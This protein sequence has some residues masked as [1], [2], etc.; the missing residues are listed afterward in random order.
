MR[1]YYEIFRIIY[2]FKKLFF[3]E[4]ENVNYTWYGLF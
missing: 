3:R 4:E 2:I 1:I